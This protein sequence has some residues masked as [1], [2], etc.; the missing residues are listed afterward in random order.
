MISQ[1]LPFAMDALAKKLGTNPVNLFLRDFKAK[2]ID[3]HTIITAIFEF[4]EMYFK[5]NMTST[6]N[7]WDVLVL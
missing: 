4:A 5:D 7:F 3:F 6:A 1:D 2:S